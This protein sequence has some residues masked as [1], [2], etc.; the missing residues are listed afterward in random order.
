M[1]WGRNFKSL[2]SLWIYSNPKVHRDQV[3][4]LHFSVFL[5]SSV[6]WTPRLI[7]LVSIFNDIINERNSGTLCCYRSPNYSARVQLGAMLSLNITQMRA[8][9]KPQK[10]PGWQ[11]MYSSHK[12]HNEQT[13]CQ[14]G[15]YVHPCFFYIF[16]F[17]Y[18]LQFSCLNIL[19]P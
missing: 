13:V 18:S 19:L 7:I 10:K 3:P 9:R 12:S 6:M 8:E 1:R 4:L 11:E 17:G 15:G 2:S 14:P 16:S 5:L